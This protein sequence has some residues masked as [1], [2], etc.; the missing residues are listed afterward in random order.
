PALELRQMS[1]KVAVTNDSIN[2]SNF[3]L[4]TGE[5]TV[6]ADGAVAQYKQTPTLAMQVAFAPLSLPEIHRFAP[7]MKEINVAPAINMKIDGRKITFDTSELAYR[8]NTS[9][10]GS[11]EFATDQRPETRFDLRGA[12][13][14]VGFAYLP[15]Q[16][17]IPPAETKLSLG[18]HVKIVIPRKPGW[19]V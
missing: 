10:A 17:H 11:V 4:R 18:Y 3:N 6:W 19:H 8:S 2:V 9:A 12:V 13:K 16:T 15:K 1:G 5:T 14:D 7:A